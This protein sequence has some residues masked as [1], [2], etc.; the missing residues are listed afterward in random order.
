MKT[1][2]FAVVG[3]GKIGA[4]HAEKLR[5][6]EG[7]E[8]V[9]V[10]D[11]IPERVEVIAKKH[12]VK[13]Y[14]AI[15]E[16]LEETDADYINI[17]TPSGLHA[18]HAIQALEAGKNVLVEKPMALNE[19]DARRMVDIAKKNSR[20][21]FSVKQNRY[22]PPVKFVGDLARSGKLGKPLM[23]AVNVYW[24]RTN[25]YYRSEPWRGT[26]QFEKSTIYSQASHFADLL[27]MFMGKPKRIFSLMEN[28]THQIEIDDTA[29]VAVDFKNGAFGSLNYTMS[30]AKQNVEGSIALFYE[31]G[32][33]KIGGEYLNTIEF[34]NVEGMDSYKLEGAPTEANDY[35]SY[36][37][38]A[39]N[40]QYIFKAIV[41]EENGLDN[42]LTKRLVT[43]EE[44]IDLIRF[45]DKAVES[46]AEKKIIDF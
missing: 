21:L 30:T 17:V 2:K 40:H 38:S 14:A 46:A 36:R 16:M 29:I 7:A 37:G 42:D 3:C 5:A 31:K 41:D 15:E 9:A 44:T 24:N 45:F 35:G 39:S 43:G 6:V 34:F 33:I 11:I 20:S 18:K 13:A 26:R 22:N 1:I 25:D 8:L 32:S 19:A 28:K 23:A 12:N 10:C 4:R 27:L